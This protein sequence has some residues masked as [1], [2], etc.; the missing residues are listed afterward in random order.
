MA[1]R[2]QNKNIGEEKIKAS[3]SNSN[4]QSITKGK[5]K[6]ENL[7]WIYW[8]RQP[9]CDKKINKLENLA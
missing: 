9:T 2:K 5:F 3:H 4:N 8:E 7:V 1:K 6:Q